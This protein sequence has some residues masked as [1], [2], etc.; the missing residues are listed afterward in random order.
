VR[1]RLM[2]LAIFVGLPVAV[3]ADGPQT[4]K[5]ELTPLSV[6]C[7]PSVNL[8]WST[9]APAGIGKMPTFQSGSPFFCQL[10]IVDK[11]PMLVAADVVPEGGKSRC[12]VYLDTN[13]NG[14]LTGEKAYTLAQV[15]LA[16]VFPVTATPEIRIP[17][18][19]RVNGADVYNAYTFRLGMDPAS[20][21]ALPDAVY[22]EYARSGIVTLGG[23][24]VRLTVCDG[25]NDAMLV[26]GEGP[27]QFCLSEDVMAP[28]SPA[29]FIP[30]RPS[31][32]YEGSHYD[33]SV[34]IDGGEATVTSYGGE[35]AL[36][37]VT[38]RDGRGQPSPVASL[39]A[40]TNGTALSKQNLQGDLTLLPGTYGLTYAMPCVD[41]RQHAYVFRAPNAMV[42][43]PGSSRRLD[44]GGPLVVD[45]LTG[46]VPAQ[47]G[48]TL[49]VSLIPHTEAGHL[50]EEM[51]RQTPVGEAVVL[52]LDGEEVGRG[53][54]AQA[55]PGTAEAQIALPGARVGARFV[56]KVSFDSGG[57][58]EPFS[59]QLKVTVKEPRTAG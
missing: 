13:W 12:T 40:V 30:L 52:N 6:A 14:S 49:D 31:F 53:A 50:F 18:R 24:Q 55:G 59:K 36:L 38:G 45:V 4:F 21:S 33:L 25:N 56:L 47:G 7:R 23:K 9:Q 10:Q 5:L 11:P 44:C 27:D 16:G 17:L 51:G 57:Y 15:E 39:E 32:E 35:L 22:V 29:A 3:L 1:A 37:T 34:R 20:G 42:L 43:G 2:C 58:Q 46:T 8:Q 54:L 28:P 41:G 19:Y 26:T 48:W